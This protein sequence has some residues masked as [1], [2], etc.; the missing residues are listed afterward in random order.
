[1]SEKKPL[2]VKTTLGLETFRLLQEA[3]D[4]YE[5]NLPENQPS[6]KKKHLAATQVLLRKIILE[7]VLYNSGSNK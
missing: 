3:V 4:Y 5:I 6:E 7:H 1:M 2:F